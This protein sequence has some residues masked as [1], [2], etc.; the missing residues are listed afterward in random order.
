M[1]TRGR[2]LT[3]P[4]WWRPAYTAP[5]GTLYVSPYLDAAWRPATVREAATWQARR[6]EHQ[7]TVGRVWDDAY[8]ETDA[9]DR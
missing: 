4:G 7:H 6:A 1:N 5:D 3:R 9:A 8:Y 2:V